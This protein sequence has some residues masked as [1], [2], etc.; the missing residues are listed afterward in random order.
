[1]SVHI[2]AIVL[3]SMVGV[4]LFFT[5]LLT[6]YFLH[7]RT[8]FAARPPSLKQDNTPST[9]SHCQLHRQPLMMTVKLQS[10]CMLKFQKRQ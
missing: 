10:T 4:L 7:F 6:F 2:Y 1:M 5:V 8:R 9:L 3:Q